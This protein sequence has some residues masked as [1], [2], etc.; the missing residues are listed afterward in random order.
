MHRGLPELIE[1][2]SPVYDAFFK[3]AE[4]R[5]LCGSFPVLPGG[6]PGS[7][8]PSPREGAKAPTQAQAL[9]SG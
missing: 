8:R 4:P 5:V 3:D 7:A 1:S 9:P 2:L 6:K